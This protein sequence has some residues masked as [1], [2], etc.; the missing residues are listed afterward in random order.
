M[1]RPQNGTRSVELGKGAQEP[2]RVK[3]PV[4]VRKERD[5][6]GMRGSRG[7]EPRGRGALVT[8]ARCYKQVVN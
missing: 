4:V 2:H 5:P 1:N 8:N 6:R 3:N 7:I